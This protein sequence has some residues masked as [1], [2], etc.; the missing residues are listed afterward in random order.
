MPHVQDCLAASEAR[1]GQG[2]G[3][4][5]LAMRPRV[6]V[7]HKAVVGQIGVAIMLDGTAWL[8]LMAP[9][10]HGGDK[11]MPLQIARRRP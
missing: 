10:R 7:L 8:A 2:G 6:D 1:S 11:A 4:T 5:V 3:A 9:G